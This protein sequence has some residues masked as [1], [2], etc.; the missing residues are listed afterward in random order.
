MRMS[1]TFVALLL[2]LAGC[3]SSKAPPSAES[4]AVAEPVGTDC[5]DTDTAAPD[6]APDTDPGGAAPDTGLVHPA[7]REGVA[8]AAWAPD[9]EIVVYAV[10]HAEKESEGDDPGLTEEGTARAEA[11]AV[12]MADVPLAAIYATELR[13]TQDTVAPTAAAHGLVVET[14]IDPEDELAAHIRCTHAGQTVLHAG[15]SYTLPDFFEA[16]GVPDVPSVSGYGQLWRV[17][18]GTDGEVTVEESRFGE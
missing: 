14:G 1:R 7:L 18:I 5:T 3:E 16:I 9:A 10:R 2:L 12:V 15:H 8:A 13:R 11:L 17:R 6:T 4:P